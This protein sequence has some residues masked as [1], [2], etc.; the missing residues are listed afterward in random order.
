MEVYKDHSVFNGFYDGNKRSGPGIMEYSNKSTFM[1]EWKHGQRSG[2][3]RFEQGDKVTSGNW[4]Y[5]R[6]KFASA[7][8]LDELMKPLYDKKL[9]NNF[10]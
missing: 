9:P 2:K 10:E 8:D 5:D 1:G 7:V 4:E 3:G 6:I